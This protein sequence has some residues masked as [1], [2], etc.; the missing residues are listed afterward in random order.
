MSASTF[1][2]VVSPFAARRTAAAR[3]FVTAHAAGGV[4][5]VGASRA[6]AD[7]LALD[8]A[9]DVGALVGVTR[10]SFAELATRLALPVL[11]ER[12]VAPGSA[13]GV[14]AMVARASFDAHD[15]G[16][17][18]YFEPVAQ[19]PGF[20]RAAART[21][22]ELQLA[23]V[24]LDALAAVDRVGPD[25]VAL[26]R[27]L[28][29]EAARSGAVSRADVMATAA[30]R[31]AAT[32]DVLPARHV[33]LLD[34]PI[35]SAADRRLLA[36]L[37]AAATS[38]LAVVP[39]GDAPARAACA[40]AGG[41]A[42]VDAEEVAATAGHDGTARAR[43]QRWLFSTD[44]PPVGALDDTVQIF[45]APGEGR[46]AVE[47]VRRVLAEADAGVPFDAMAV[48]LRAPH[49]YLGL[50]EHA[51]ARA[52][53]PAWFERGTRRPDPAGRAFLALLACADD[54]LSARR[55][56]EYLS[57]GQVPS[58]TGPIENLQGPVPD[59]D[60]L[61]RPDERVED[62]APIDEAPAAT[63]RDGTRVVAG[64]LSAPWRWEE[65]LV[66]ACVI[67]GLERWQRR[68][69]GLRHEYD[70]RWRELADEDRDSPRLRALERDREQL[71]HLESFALPIVAVIDT[72]RTPRTWAAWLQEFTALVPR[73]LRQ[74]A[75]VARVL[76]EM[77]PLGAVGP[78]RL[79]EVRDV[80]TPRLLTLTH[81]P[82]RRRQGQVFIGTPQSARGRTFSVV[83]VP[84]MAERIFP[85]RLRED[86]LLLDARRAALDPA[87]PVTDTRADEER[88]Q[89]RL[90][91]GAATA[92]VHLSYPRLE[93]AESRPR[94]P[95]F[96]VLD[97]VRA[98]TG[99]IPR[100][101]AVAEDAS[102]RGGAR[103]DWPAPRD[104]RAA[105][106]DMEHDLAVLLPL[107]RAPAAERARDEGRARYLL[108]LNAPLRRSVIERWS[109]WQS[110]WSQADGLTRVQPLTAPA[111]AAQRLTA[112]PYSLTALQRYA[113]CPYQFQ[114]AAIYQLAPLEAPA[115]LQR[116]DPL[117]RGSLFHEIQTDFFRTLVKNG[118]LPL[119]PGHA[120]PARAQLEWAIN[121]VTKKAYDDLAPAIDRVWRD[122]IAGLRRDLYLWFDD[123]VVR[124]A[125]QWV[126]ERFELAFG[127]P[128]DSARD[129]AS[130][131]EPVAVGEPGFRLRGS[132]DLV[133]RRLSDKALRV[134][135]HKTGKN[136]TTPATIVEGGRVLQPVLYA[137]AL[138]VMTGERVVEGRLSYCTTAG[139]F[140]ER[141]ITLDEHIRRRG[142]EVLEIVD[143]AIEH[144][145]LAARPGQV[146]GRPACDYCDFRAVCGPD[147]PRRTARKPEVP[148]LEALRRM[149]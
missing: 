85:Q 58:G 131:R 7:E 113:A 94:V 17:L 35:V 138:E 46:E 104:P 52:G 69:P 36:A 119:L 3:A 68:L 39:E 136:R 44:A 149:P 97:V 10:M 123:M 120:A 81:E 93:L 24:S 127:L 45:S 42:P 28:D 106:D 2:Y 16:E 15:A 66:E 110:R 30:A 141:A 67:E 92:R 132:I 59:A 101:D 73:V 20:P 31:V 88:L 29:D 61:L 83:F 121:A 54:G 60:V 63:E 148:D 95:S 80:L 74:P 108:E 122:E 27:R 57:L 114:L 8:I 14:E 134:T 6:A 116:L 128:L 51:F 34:V 78:V 111:L 76:A 12:L 38:C 1:Q 41:V 143:R 18:A 49:T 37:A 105:I 89:L 107:L 144:G 26:A 32:P 4:L 50:L 139:Q 117:T 84:G 62:P 133:E 9:R 53:V 147:E 124:D 96:Y 125:A 43:L 115:P 103:L 64:T 55:F 98:T 109:R 23:G 65:L 21:I 118:M 129:A 19:L 47:V 90:A 99:A 25:L 71:G 70:R 100:Y 137:V 135:D 112:R 11:A 79:R 102:A 22:G 5:I 75:R 13:L 87:L 40:I 33:L 77:A 86:A 72:W 145:M 140:S 48:L 82:P 56:A 130:M 146:A 126:P 142:L 91:V